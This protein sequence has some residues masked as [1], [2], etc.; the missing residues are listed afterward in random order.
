MLPFVEPEDKPKTAPLPKPPWHTRIS[1]RKL[2]RAGLAGGALLGLGGLLAWHTLGYEVPWAVKRRLRTL[3]PKEYLIVAAAAARI[4]RSEDPAYP[5]PEDVE[6]AFFVDELAAALDPAALDDLKK[7]LHVLEHALPISTGRPDRFTRLDGEAQ[8]AVLR[9]M[10]ESSIGLMRGGFDALKS[11]CAMA[12]F[13]D[14]RTWDAIG[15]DGP[16]VGRPSGGW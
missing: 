14:A 2:L 5:S 10:S 1:R 11:L 13:R 4:L 8:D 9:A 3:S 15:Y 16:L 7:L 6:A 12:Y